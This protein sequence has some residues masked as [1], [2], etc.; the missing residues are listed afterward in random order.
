MVLGDGVV[1]KTVLLGNL[2]SPA[3]L[4]RCGDSTFPVLSMTM[5]D[6]IVLQSDRF[7]KNLASLD[8]S[9]Y[10]VVKRG[11]LVVGFP[12]DEGV[13]YVQSIADAGIMSP[14]YSVWNIDTNKI[15]PWF[16]ELSLHSPMAMQFYRD[17]LRGTT[18]RRRSIP[19]EVL[20]SLPLVLPSMEEQQRIAAVLNKLGDL[21]TFR[22][23]QLAKLDELAQAWFVEMVGDLNVNP[24]RWKFQKLSSLCDVRDGTHDSPDYVKEGCPLLTSKNFTS[25]MIDFTNCNLI[26]E[27]D[28]EQIN[29]RSKVDRGDIIM[30]MIGT[31]GHPVIVD[32]DRPFA[33]KNVALIKFNR[34]KISNIFVKKILDSDYFLTATKNANRGGTQKFIALGDIRNIP[35]PIVPDE[36]QEEIASY[37]EGVDR[38][39]LTIQQGLDKLEVLKK[40][41]M[42]EYF[43]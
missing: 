17:N 28:F 8:Q 40:S 11:Q 6:G 2:I 35:I 38:H 23:Q 10:K 5:H 31:I 9:N 1:K 18:A 33:I 24:M 43:G 32:T 7:K 26:S 30:P 27:K 21:I 42:Q 4:L 14:A 25:G 34:G 12:I 16:L 22:K 36:L 13:L 20:L 19:T 15:S 39:K 3:P 29:R 37:S 41:L